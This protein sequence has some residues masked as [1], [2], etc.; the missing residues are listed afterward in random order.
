MAKAKQVHWSI[1]FGTSNTTVCEDRAGEPHIVNLNGLAK[2]EPLTQTPIIPSA[3]CVLDRAAAKVL[4]GQAAVAYNW[5]GTAAGFAHGFKRQL[6]DESSR[7]IIRVDGQPFNVRQVTQLYF[8]ELV[9]K[10]EEQFG[11]PV[12]DVTVAAPMG[13]FETYR[14]EL[15]SIVRG[16]VK[17]PWWQRMLPFL[18]R[19][20]MTVRFIDEPVAAALGY[21]VNVGH[22]QTIVGL[23]FG[24]GTL[25]I[26]AIRTRAGKT[27]ESGTAEVLGKQSL[28]LGGDDIDG[29]IVER[30]A[31]EPLRKLDMHRV[32]LKWEAE[33]TKLLASAGQTGHFTFNN[34]NYGTLD[35]HGLAELLAERALYRNLQDAMQRLLDELRT[36]HGLEV[37]QIDEVLLEGGSTLLPE[38]RN[39]IG[40]TFGREKVREWLPFESVA[41]GACIFAGGAQVDDFIYHDYALRVLDEKTNAVEYEQLIPRGTRYPT[42]AD[43]VSR[44]YA[45]GYEGQQSLNLF[46]CEVGRVA[47]RPVDWQKR[48]NGTEYFQP[49]TDGDHAFCLCLN[50]GDEALSLNPP[51]RGASPRVRVTY[52]VNGSRWL[53]VTVHDLLRKVD[54]KVNE[55]VIRLR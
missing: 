55:P 19:G 11:E 24:A 35:Y 29:W 46:I 6:G 39:L 1:D 21:G 10:L 52:S 13:F 37:R 49:K 31:P 54:L 41:R 15:Q 16:L 38:V 14:A 51:G 18:R 17:V 20:G 23:D 45:P 9:A 43:F 3:V 12:L 44:Y 48:P 4:I 30:F 36:R 32:A 47:G 33:R 42:Q 40:E 26:A 7:Q 2:S 25:E 22:D 8:R 53:C 28:R 34:Q 50:E 27:S 5:D